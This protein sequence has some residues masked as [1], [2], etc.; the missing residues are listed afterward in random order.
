[1]FKKILIANRGEIALR[2]I[3]ACKELG[4]RTVAVHSE[5]DRN[6]LHVRF[7]DESVCIGPADVAESYLNIPA[8]ISA[9]LVTGAD[10]I[11]P[12]YGFLSE[13]SQFAEVCESS[14]IHFIGPSPE[15]IR[16]MGDKVEAKI[17]AKKVGVP[18]VPGSEGPIEDPRE[19]M[20]VAKKIGFP[21]LIKA[22]GGGGGRG[23]KIV[24][25]VDELDR[26]VR[27]A[28]SEALLA[29]GNP[30]VYLEKLIV[31]PRH[32]EIQ[33]MADRQGKAISLYER[34]CSIQRRYQKVVEEA[35][36]VG[37]P[38]DLRGRMGEAACALA[39]ASGFYTVGTVEFLVDPTTFEFYFI[40]M[41]TRVQVEHPVTEAIT[42]IDIVRTQILLAAGERLRL[43]QKDI[44]INGHA[45]EC[46]ITAEDPVLFRPSPGTITTYHQPGGLGVR[47]D[48]A[49]YGG[50]RVLPFYDS[51]ISKLIV[52]G[53]DRQETL[54][55]LSCA[56]DEYVIEG[57]QTTL[58]FHRRLMQYQPYRDGLLHTGLIKEMFEAHEAG[59]VSGGTH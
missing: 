14:G 6:S 34:D 23:M 13:R 32:V 58:P 36:A 22:A 25:N 37:L 46:R 20:R 11:H 45:I 7:A 4:V 18:M 1:M 17:L 42:G 29:F 27:M 19:A 51:L 15:S 41:N 21:V 49:A 53:A 56:L 38:P 8:V 31:N 39:E 24:N 26:M 43:K 50:Y 2:V 44:H 9:A 40:E 57:I 33:V 47:V 16:M 12:G 5:P 59:K 35:P 3:R 48:S 52:H 28:Q 10:G 55:R 30:H 54:G